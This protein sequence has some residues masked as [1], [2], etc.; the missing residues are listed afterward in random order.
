MSHSSN[1]NDSQEATENSPLLPEESIDLTDQETSKL[2][3]I[4]DFRNPHVLWMIVFSFTL[5]TIMTSI[6]APL[7]QIVLDVVCLEY[8]ELNDNNMNSTDILSNLIE[9]DCKDPQIF[10]LAAT[11]LML[12]QICLYVSATLSIGY[13]STLSDFKGRR[14]VFRI[15]TLGI[16]F[17]CSVVI[18]MS[19][20]WK[21][22]G[23]NFL[24]I[25]AIVE[26]LLGGVIAINTACHAY[27]SDCTK[28]VNRS[29]A[30]GFMHASAYCGMS[31]GPILGGI[32]VEATGSALSV[33]YVVICALSVFFIFVS[34]ILPESLSPELRLQNESSTSFPSPKYIFSALIIL[35]QTPVYSENIRN[36]IW[37][38]NVLYILSIIYF[39]YRVSQ[40]GQNDIIALYTTRKFGWTTLENGFFFTLQAS[41][42]FMALIVL[43]PLIRFLQG[44]YLTTYSRTLDLVMMRIGLIIEIAG[45]TLFATA[46]YPNMFY[47]ACVVNSLATIATP[48]IRTLF[49]IFVL[50]TQ[51]GQILGAMSVIESV[52]SI[53]SPLFLNSLY[54]ISV[55]R[56]FDEIVFWANSLLFVLATFLAFLVL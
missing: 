52:G 12:Y 24:F 5:S 25:G 53:L 32:I 40:A 45:F 34:F 17:A 10:S 48:A 9:K 30:F 22:I 38:R 19:H 51:A 44:K 33:F 37:K 6:I 43:L 8:Y 21:V 28:P 3:F 26:G 7:V 1:H 56:G 4:K 23:S 55:L 2:S 41:T 18:L 13:I 50:P 11:R 46:I 31:I 36:N 27:I 47:F 49:T 15:S 14:F 29:V 42:R 54:S 16:I 20:H 39:I 35:N